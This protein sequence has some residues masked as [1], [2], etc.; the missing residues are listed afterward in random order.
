M[1]ALIGCLVLTFGGVSCRESSTHTQ[2]DNTQRQVN[3]VLKVYYERYPFDFEV[4]GPAA[5]KEFREV[6]VKGYEEWADHMRKINRPAGT[7]EDSSQGRECARLEGEYREGDELYF[8]RS[9]ERSWSDLFG[10]EGYV[11]IREGKIVSLVET[12][13]S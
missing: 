9:E 8:F 1:K 10:R 4:R 5:L 2:E 7:F 11:L 12:N 3:R 6:W 13:V